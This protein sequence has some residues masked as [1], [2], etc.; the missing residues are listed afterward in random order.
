M[1]DLVTASL[2]RKYN[3]YSDDHIL[4]NKLHNVNRYGII[5]HFRFRPRVKMLKVLIDNN[6]HY[7]T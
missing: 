3:L 2:Q 6:A 1:T 7:V 5:S 4:N